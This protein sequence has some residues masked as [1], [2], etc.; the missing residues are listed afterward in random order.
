VLE[1]SGKAGKTYGLT[2]SD[3]EQIDRI[4]GAVGTGVSHSVLTGRVFIEI[5]IPREGSDAY[6]RKNI[7]INFKSKTRK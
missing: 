7:V 2:I 3:G 4:E 1:V 6:P 5:N